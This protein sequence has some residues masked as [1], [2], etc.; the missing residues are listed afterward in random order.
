MLVNSVEKRLSIL[1]ADSV[2]ISECGGVDGWRDGDAIV[3]YRE[4]RGM[5]SSRDTIEGDFGQEMGI[6]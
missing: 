4:T 3:E 2:S 1:D 5:R 6:N